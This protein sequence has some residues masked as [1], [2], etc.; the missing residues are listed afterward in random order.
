MS[1]TRR[2]RC[3]ECAQQ[4]RSGMGDT[5]LMARH[6]LSSRGLQRVLVKLVEANMLSHAELYERSPLYRDASVGM[7]SRTDSRLDLTV[8]IYIYDADSPKPGLL[9]NLSEKGLRVAGIRAK[10]GD[11]KQFHIPVDVFTNADPI[12]FVARCLWVDIKGKKITYPVA[13]FEITEI[14]DHDLETL[15][16]FMDFL[17]LSNSGEWQTVP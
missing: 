3:I 10:V 6:G 7:K 17:V 5:E 14:T 2:I 12:N 16:N 8:P 1:S 13:G 4:I 9:R 11:L 15:K